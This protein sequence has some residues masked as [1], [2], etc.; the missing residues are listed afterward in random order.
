M[1]ITPLDLALAWMPRLI[2]AAVLTLGLAAVIF[3]ISAVFGLM[4]A[5]TNRDGNK[6]VRRCI[7][8][9]S[10]FFRSIPELVILFFFYFG[11]RQLGLQ[12]GPVGSTILAFGL[13]G[14]AYDYQVFKGALGAVSNGQF[15]A[16]RALGLRP[17]KAYLLVILPQML[18]IARKG[19]ITYAIGTIKRISIASAVS[20]SEIMYVTKQAIA[21]SNAPFLFLSIAVGL[22]IVIVMPL[23][24]FNERRQGARL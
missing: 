19:W 6:W 14:I 13:V 7:E 10:G 5:M 22:Y 3:A 9:F 11:G 21:A 4:L 20:V 2:W 8:M 18:P 17:W 15:E 23:L 24:V 16:A 1:T 12:F